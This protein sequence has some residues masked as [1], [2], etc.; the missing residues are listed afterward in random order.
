MSLI[1]AT[2]VL[3]V[4]SF[5][6]AMIAPSVRS[7]VQSAQQATAKKDVEAIGTAIARMLG[8]VGESFILR[9]GAKSATGD[10]LAHGAPSHDHTTNRV[11]MLV[12]S[13]GRVPAKWATI[14]RGAGT[15]WDTASAATGAVQVLDNFLVLNTP[16]TSAAN[17]YRTAATMNGTLG[18]DPDEGQTYNSE[19]AWRGGYLPG[20]IGSD[21]WG[22]RYA[23]NVEFLARPIGAGPLGNVSDVFVLSAG[24]NGLVETAFEIDGV[25]SGSD[26]FFLLSGGTR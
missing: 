26:I 17:A 5:L 8:D 15:D 16:N 10:A 14:A 19:H 22:F 25:T 4:L 9:N 11:D 18:F 2:V 13:E 7:Y 20:P 3:A 12:S 21:P 6:S 24:S 23:V 1:E